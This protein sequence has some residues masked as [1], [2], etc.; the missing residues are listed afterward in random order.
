MFKKAF[1][2]R[3]P[4]VSIKNNNDSASPFES[5]DFCSHMCLN[6]FGN[7]ARRQHKFWLTV[8]GNIPVI[9]IK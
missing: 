4:F 3:D 8:I 5:A 9:C 2:I 7:L 1:E 6:F